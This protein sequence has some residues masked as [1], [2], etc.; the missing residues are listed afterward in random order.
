MPAPNTIISTHI[1]RQLEYEI[2]DWE[3]DDIYILTDT[4]TREKCLPLLF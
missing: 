3:R 1:I 4:N 2:R